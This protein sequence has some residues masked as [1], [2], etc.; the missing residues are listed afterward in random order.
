M[1]KGD[2]KHAYQTRYYERDDIRAQK[3]AAAEAAAAAAKRYEVSA[4]HLPRPVWWDS[5]HEV[6][7]TWAA[8]GLPVPP[9]RCIEHDVLSEELAPDEVH[10]P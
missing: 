5:Q 4:L 1:P 7:K 8:R 10:A 2:A 6:V 9:G 3:H